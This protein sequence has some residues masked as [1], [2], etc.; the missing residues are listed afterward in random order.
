[1]RSRSGLTTKA[2][3]IKIRPFCA[4]LTNTKTLQFCKLCITTQPHVKL[5]KPLGK[6]EREAKVAYASSFISLKYR[7]ILLQFFNREQTVVGSSL[8]KMDGF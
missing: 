3:G 1:M 5:L 7:I 4:K 6:D 2:D 8:R